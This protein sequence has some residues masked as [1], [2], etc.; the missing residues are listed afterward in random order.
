MII[1]KDFTLN[2]GPVDPYKSVKFDP[3]LIQENTRQYIADMT[4]KAI[5]ET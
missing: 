3:F 2:Y 5:F 1:I 4:K